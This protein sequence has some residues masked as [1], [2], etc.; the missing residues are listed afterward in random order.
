MFTLPDDIE[1][2]EID[3]EC[4]KDFAYR[5]LNLTPQSP[6]LNAKVASL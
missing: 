4:L 5:R 2:C 3:P 6:Y 1:I